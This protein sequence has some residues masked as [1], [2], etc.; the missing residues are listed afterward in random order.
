MMRPTLAFFAVFFLLFACA[1]NTEDAAYRQEIAAERMAMNEHFFD[2]KESPL[3]SAL[4]ASFKGLKF[5]PVSEKYRVQATLTLL[6]QQAI[7]DLPH[8]HERSKPYKQY[9]KIAFQLDGK[10]YELTV[11]EQAQKR[12]GLENYLL[13]PFTDETSGKT[14]YGGGRYIDLD[15]SAGTKITLDFNQSYHPY[16]LYN[17]AYTCP[18]PPKENHLPITIEAGIKAEF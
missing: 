13:L 5:F 7:F 10:Q 18:I 9:A 11:L 14:S 4:F 15:K 6:A 3:D 12:P 16:C 2:S 17:A 1:D 8:S